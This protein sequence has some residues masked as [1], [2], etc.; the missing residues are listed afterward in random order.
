MKNDL[1]GTIN[2]EEKKFNLLFIAILSPL[3]LGVI[4]ISIY[5]IS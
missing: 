5:F 4:I 1:K 2:Q 3:I